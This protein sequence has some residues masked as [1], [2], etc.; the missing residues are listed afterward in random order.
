MC[1]PQPNMQNQYL[2]VDNRDRLQEGSQWTGDG[3]SNITKHQRETNCTPSSKEPDDWRVPSNFLAFLLMFRIESQ[4][5]GS[6]SLSS[7]RPPS[8]RVN[9]TLPIFPFLTLLPTRFADGL[10]AFL[11]W[12]LERGCSPPPPR[13]GGVR[14]ATV[15]ITPF[16]I[17][18]GRVLV[19]RTLFSMIQFRWMIRNPTIPIQPLRSSLTIYP[20]EPLPA[21]SRPAPCL[22]FLGCCRVTISHH[23]LPD[24]LLSDTLPGCHSTHSGVET[25]EDQYFVCRS[26][27]CSLMMYAMDRFVS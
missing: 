21:L 9:P 1:P 10:F 8:F 23:C 2:F 22:S 14:S 15:I 13:S 16:I 17:I 25:T 27:S 19:T 18:I 26:Q 5:R 20:V 3:T 12:V 7:S 11:S 4:N 6:V 24:L